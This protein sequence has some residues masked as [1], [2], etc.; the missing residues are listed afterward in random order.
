MNGAP[1]GRRFLFRLKAR[2][3]LSDSLLALSLLIFTHVVVAKPL[4]SF[5][6]HALCRAGGFVD[7][8]VRCAAGR[9]GGVFLGDDGADHQ[10]DLVEQHQR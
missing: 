3:G 10:L 5:A 6:R 2:R 7:F 8:L 9:G 1:M 4:H